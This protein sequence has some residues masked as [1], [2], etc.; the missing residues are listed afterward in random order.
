LRQT[1]SSVYAELRVISLSRKPWLGL[2]DRIK[3]KARDSLATTLRQTQIRV[4]G[5]GA[6]VP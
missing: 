1:G 5:L 2:H 3:V 6:I 4:V